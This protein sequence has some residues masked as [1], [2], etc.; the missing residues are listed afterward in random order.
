MPTMGHIISKASEVLPSTILLC[1]ELLFNGHRVSQDERSSVA[2]QWQSLPNNAN[3]FNATGM[4]LKKQN[5]RQLRW[6]MLCYFI[7]TCKIMKI[8]EVYK[9]VFKRETVISKRLYFLNGIVH[10][11]RLEIIPHGFLRSDR[12]CS[13]KLHTVTEN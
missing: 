12:Q 5:K 4:H 10:S 13:L 8:T 11:I 9:T 2:G 6:Q 7:T 1:E 3:V